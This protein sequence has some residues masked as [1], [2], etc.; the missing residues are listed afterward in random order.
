V[1]SCIEQT[2]PKIVLYSS[3]V[4]ESV[5]SLGVLSSLNVR[6]LVIIKCHQ[7]LLVGSAVVLI[8]QLCVIVCVDLCA[9]TCI[10]GS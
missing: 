3:N 7:V 4:S 9:V 5:K 2:L 1:E 8:Y 10:F 6:K